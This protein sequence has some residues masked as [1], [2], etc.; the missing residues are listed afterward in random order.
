M[1]F[2]LM[3]PSGGSEVAPMHRGFPLGAHLKF[4][5]LFPARAFAPYSRAS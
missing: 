2:L 5:Y 1:H 4:G 3:Q